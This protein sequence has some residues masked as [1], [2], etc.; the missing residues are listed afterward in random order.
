M[1]RPEGFTQLMTVTTGPLDSPVTGC[2]YINPEHY[3]MNASRI[4]VWS[5]HSHRLLIHHARDVSVPS[6]LCED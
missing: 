2:G 6:W 3:E 4:V 5:T 1:V